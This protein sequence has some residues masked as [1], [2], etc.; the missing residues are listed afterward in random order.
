MGMVMQVVLGR[1]MVE[2]LGTRSMR[3]G[4]LVVVT[5][6]EGLSMG[7]IMEGELLFLRFWL[8]RWE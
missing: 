1:G 4:R 2:G 7:S 6:V 5:V 3:L 8:C